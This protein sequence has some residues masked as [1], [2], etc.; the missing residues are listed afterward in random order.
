MILALIIFLQ[1][2]EPLTYQI[3]YLPLREWEQVD[4]RTLRDSI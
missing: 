1:P 3:D 2:M 4:D